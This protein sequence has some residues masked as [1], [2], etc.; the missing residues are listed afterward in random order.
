MAENSWYYISTSVEDLEYNDDTLTLWYHWAE[1]SLDDL[2]EDDFEYH[3][4]DE[5]VDILSEGNVRKI[6]IDDELIFQVTLDSEGHIANVKNAEGEVYDFGVVNMPIED[7]NVNLARYKPSDPSNQKPVKR[8]FTIEEANK[9]SGK[10]NT[11][12]LRYK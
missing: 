11:V 2:K 12:K 7:I 8:I 10:V 3:D 1:I 5:G 9:V 6:Y 4:E